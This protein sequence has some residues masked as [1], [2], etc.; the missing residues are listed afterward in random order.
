MINGNLQLTSVVEK[1]RENVAVLQRGS[2]NQAPKDGCHARM[3]S[4]FSK[5]STGGRQ[6]AHQS[7]K[8]ARAQ[9]APLLPLSL[10]FIGAQSPGQIPSSE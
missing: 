1:A 7:C 2:C 4:P 6:R 10:V 3:W 8:L 5:A 9:F